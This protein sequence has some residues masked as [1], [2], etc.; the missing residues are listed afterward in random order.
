M[1]ELI[2]LADIAVKRPGVGIPPEKIGCIAGQKAL[3]DIKRES[4]FK[5]SHV[6]PLKV[7][8]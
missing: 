7:K 4:L 2:R 5:F 6:S 1:G 8:R 3:A